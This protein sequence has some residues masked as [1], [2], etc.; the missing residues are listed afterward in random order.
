MPDGRFAA[1]RDEVEHP[2]LTL[3]AVLAE[4]RVLASEVRGLREA[5]GARPRRIRGADPDK[6]A[7]L[8]VAIA[9]S[10]G[11]GREFAVAELQEFAA[12]LA[13]RR[14]LCDALAAVG[15]DPRR[16]GLFLRRVAGVPANGLILER[17]G[18]DRA[19][20]VWI[21]RDQSGS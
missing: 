20:A 14:A 11:A 8:L 3:A 15:S 18:G 5:L 10:W 9:E 1:R 21:V 7:H 6:L 12:A 4:L 17:I 2:E 13:T 19:G 16:V